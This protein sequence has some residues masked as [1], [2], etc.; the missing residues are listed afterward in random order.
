MRKLLSL[1]LL[2]V[3]V[4]VF[5]QS[6]PITAITI[7]LP[8]NP[9]AST[10]KWA[11]GPS[12]LTITASAKPVNGRTDPRLESGKI[13][14]SIKKGGTK[15]CGS[16][17]PASA[18]S[19]NF[20][21]ATKVWT[22]NNA[23]SLLGQEC[24]LPAGDYEFCVQFFGQGP[25][26]LAPLSEEKCKPFSI[27]DN[28][29][30]SFN[31]PINVTPVDNKVFTENEIK[32]PITF[33][34][35]PVIPK[36]RETV[37]YRVRVWQ[38]MQGQ[39][40][41]QAI[42]SNTPDISRDVDNLTQASVIVQ[43]RQPPPTAFIWNVQ[44]LNRDG[45]PIGENNGTSEAFR[46]TVQPVND[47]PSILKLLM[48]KNGSI[49][50]ANE[51]PK[52]TWT[53]F[54]PGDLD[55]DGYYKIKIVEIK[56]DE[57]PESAIRGNKPHFEKDSLIRPSFEY[58]TSAPKFESG[59]KYAWKIEARK[60]GG[61]KIT[62]SEINEFSIAS[63]SG[64]PRQSVSWQTVAFELNKISHCAV[65][66]FACRSYTDT[67]TRPTQYLWTG[68]FSLFYS[69]ADQNKIL[70]EAKS[71]A[72]YNRP[73]GCGG[74]YKSIISIT[75][76]MAPQGN[77]VGISIRYG[78]CTR[79]NNPQ[80]GIALIKFISPTF[81]SPTES[82]RPEFKWKNESGS[83]DLVY[84][85]ILVG[86]N[87]YQYGDPLRAFRENIAIV[88]KEF[89]S[90]TSLKYPVDASSLEKGKGYAWTVQ[91]SKKGG[92]FDDFPTVFRTFV[93]G[94]S[95]PSQAM[96]CS[97]CYL[98]CTIEGGGCMN[99]GIGSCFCFTPLPIMSFFWAT[100]YAVDNRDILN[101][102]GVEQL[103]I[104]KGK[105]PFDADRNV[106]LPFSNR[107]RD[108][109][110]D[111][112]KAMFEGYPM[113]AAC[114]ADGNSCIGGHYPNPKLMK[115]KPSFYT[116]DANID[117]EGFVKGITLSYKDRAVDGSNTGN[118]NNPGVQIK[119]LDGDQTYTG[120]CE[121]E[122]TCDNKMYPYGEGDKLG[123]GEAVVSFK[124]KN[125][126][127]IG[128]FLRK[129]PEK[130]DSKVF[131]ITKKITLNKE[132]C[133][134]L[135][136][137]SLT[138]LPGKYDIDRSTNKLGTI[139]LNTT[140]G[141]PQETIGSLTYITCKCKDNVGT[142]TNSCY[143]TTDCSVCC[144]YCRAKIVIERNGGVIFRTNTSTLGEVNT[145]LDEGEY[146]LTLS[147]V[148]VDKV[149][150]IVTLIPI[151]SKAVT[152]K[153]IKV[154]EELQKGISISMPGEGTATIAVYRYIGTE[155]LVK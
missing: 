94:S 121:G 152:L 36:P 15:I 70:S 98:G 153:F 110:K 14:V 93:G 91:S 142:Y 63:N 109:R 105:Y 129:S 44:A 65:D 76:V 119:I 22:G 16:Y 148:E 8:A 58:P 61:V 50:S 78:C 10:I 149:S 118:N 117:K 39:N 150:V 99:N 116:I 135:G 9:D 127:L 17:T 13:L 72:F 60:K 122:G 108:N 25:T 89:I 97:D 112:N 95:E 54:F 71:W 134:K 46:F 100:D 30:Q 18:P 128:E 82:L 88:D 123:K 113:N 90:N 115:G 141:N 79:M 33:R 136:G 145:K 103:T 57:S 27:A 4:Q 120:G 64:C 3:S 21:A 11:T 28:T 74:A 19:A 20:N 126:F 137:G 69:V 80:H 84:R 51:N 56:G 85:V 31:P 143:S 107:I 130:T 24:I 102:L 96:P 92:K 140:L 124:L 7:S 6:Y 48:P 37:T 77:S 147:D 23:V 62:E 68:Q 139:K 83:N 111:K 29:Q 43:L 138:I 104:S 38:L 154:K 133:E 53:N 42:K 52:F 26:G 146:I 144:T 75:Y 101:Y 86:L 73:I 67:V 125:G 1:L 66:Q 35:T 45:K 59:K 41:M 114:N 106:V 151:K 5:S 131:T 47:P 87:T 40:G 132:I 55:G 81:E 12:M 155:T 2:A 49:L 34:W 32:T